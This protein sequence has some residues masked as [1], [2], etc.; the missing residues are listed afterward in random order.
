MSLSIF[1]MTWHIYPPALS[2]MNQVGAL[3]NASVT[4]SRNHMMNSGVRD[5][6]TKGATYAKRDSIS[7]NEMKYLSV[8]TGN[9]GMFNGPKMSLLKASPRS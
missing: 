4:L 8:P 7:I 2:L 5:R 9:P 3:P 6:T 1:V